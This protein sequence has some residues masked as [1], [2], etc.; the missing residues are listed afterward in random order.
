MGQKNFMI[1]KKIYIFTFFIIG[2]F[3]FSSKYFADK[4]DL[5]SCENKIYHNAT[6]EEEFSTESVMVVLSSNASSLDTN[7][8]TAYFNIPECYDVEL[9]TTPVSNSNISE[10]KLY[11]KVLALKLNQCTKERILEIL[12]ELIKK[13]EIIYAGPDYKIQSASNQSEEL[14]DEFEAGTWGISEIE[15]EKCW[16][17]TEGSESLVVGIIDTGIDGTHAELQSSILTNLCMHFEK[18]DPDSSNPTFAET[19]EF[20]VDY[21]G[22]GTLV[23]GI[24]AADGNNPYGVKG[25]VPDVKIVSLRAFKDT[26][27]GYLSNVARAIQFAQRN[28]IKLLNLSAVWYEGTPPE[29]NDFVIETIISQYPGLIICTAGNYFEY[30]DIENDELPV[31]GIYSLPNMIVVG[32]LTENNVRWYKSNYGENYV[33]VYAPG[34]RI[35]STFSQLEL[36][37]PPSTDTIHSPGF[38]YSDGTSMATPY[39][40]GIAALLWSIEP[41]LS[42]LEIKDSIINGSV[43]TTIEL[44]EEY[45]QGTFADVQKVNALE[46]LNYCLENY[47]L[48]KRSFSYSSNTYT[49]EVDSSSNYLFENSLL[50]EIEKGNFNNFV[51]LSAEHPIEFTLYD[52][53]F[54]E[55]NITSTYSNNNCKITFDSILSSG[56]YY[57]K[58]NFVNENDFGDI[59]VSMHY[60]NFV[61]HYCTICN[62]YTTSHSFHSPYVFVNNINHTAQCGCGEQTLQAHAIKSGTNR[63]LLCNGIVGQGFIEINLNT[64]KKEYV[65]ANGSYVLS[66]GI[67]ILVEEDIKAY[68][69]G[70]LEFKKFGSVIK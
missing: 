41:N 56:E 44:N 21:N 63:C 14:S 25:V 59:S 19:Q 43:T 68:L 18:V 42:I 30:I 69:E 7:F 36:A 29:Y 34:D 54:N 46:I 24:I 3:A 6:V 17:F 47:I 4:V 48:E 32:A 26:G 23:A 51:E 57:L 20:P 39:V 28:G 11:K 64:N 60:H 55:I 65:S 62:M 50:L 61:D 66:N 33:D 9:L 16:N 37:I 31:P 12:D 67:V 53:E 70:V 38:A 40:T 8:D 22:H 27:T 1:I 2:L 49:Q 10:Q 52:K 35:L 45:I 13:D 5:I 15:L 58:V